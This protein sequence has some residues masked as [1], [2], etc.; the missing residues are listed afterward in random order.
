MLWSIVVA[1]SVL[2]AALTHAVASKNTRVTAAVDFPTQKR[3]PAMH[4]PIDPGV[5]QPQ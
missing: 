4:D 2:A 5:A 1:I 3:I